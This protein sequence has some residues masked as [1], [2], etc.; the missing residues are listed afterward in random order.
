MGQE[1]ATA[2]TPQG[3]KTPTDLPTR[4]PATSPR[5][6]G[7]KLEAPNPTAAPKV[8]EV[9]AKQPAVWTR[10]RWSLMECEYKSGRNR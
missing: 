7:P 1:A 4:N 6:R 5:P 2:I 9:P 10:G 8:V 3:G